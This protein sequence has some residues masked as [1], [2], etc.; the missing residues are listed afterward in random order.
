MRHT[1]RSLDDFW[2]LSPFQVFVV[3]DAVGAIRRQPHLAH[4]LAMAQQAGVEIERVE[5]EL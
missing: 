4:F 2:Q 5:D 1:Q 3:L